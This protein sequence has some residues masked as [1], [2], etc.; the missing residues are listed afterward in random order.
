METEQKAAIS[1]HKPD[2]KEKI[3]FFISGLL[4]SV[5]FTV[6]FSEFSNSLCVAMPLLFAQVC[7]LVIFAPFIEEMAKVFPLFYRHGETERSILDLGILVGLG[8]G[9]TE[10]ALYVFAL[11]A[12]FISRV[13]GVIFHAS[14]T[15]ITAYGIAKKK[16]V[17]FYLI[18]VAFH[19]ANNFFALFSNSFWFLFIPGLIILIATYLLAWYLYRRT[20]ETRVV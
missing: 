3:F 20:S 14:S 9:V 16:P 17:P 2:I 5:P 11:G 10:F 8:F 1:V 13:P 4:V 6:F 15:G 18:A 12:S 19:L 7:S